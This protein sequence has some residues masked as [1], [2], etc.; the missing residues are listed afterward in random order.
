MKKK[1]AK[2]RKTFTLKQLKFIKHFIEC[3]NATEAARRA[4][5][6]ERTA[7]Q[8]ASENLTK[9]DF[10]EAIADLLKQ[11]GLTDDMLVMKISEGTN[12]METK[13]FQKDGEVRDS[14]EVTAWDTRL[15][16]I[17]TALKLKGYLRQKVDI[18]ATVRA[19]ELIPV[20]VSNFRVKDDDPT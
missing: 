9:P 6:S 12:A 5:Y 1:P 8:I 2:K 11:H 7:K 4:G 15:R 14:R 20:D 16:Y 19:H 13:F 18:D 3:G 17:E 10:Q